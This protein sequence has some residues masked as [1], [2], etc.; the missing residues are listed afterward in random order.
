[1][2]VLE[3]FTQLM[4]ETIR[5]TEEAFTVHFME[6]LLPYLFWNVMVQEPGFFAISFKL[7]TETI[8]G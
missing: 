3:P 8:S 7:D 1:M 6:T 2:L 4:E 5:Y